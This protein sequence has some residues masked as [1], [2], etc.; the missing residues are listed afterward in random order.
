MNKTLFD[1]IGIESFD[2]IDENQGYQNIVFR[3]TKRDFVTVL[4]WHPF[5]LNDESFWAKHAEKIKTLLFNRIKFNDKYYNTEQEFLDFLNQNYPRYSPQEKMDNLLEYLHS[6][7]SF[8]GEIINYE[9]T[10][11]DDS[12]QIWRKLYF[13][14][15]A[16]LDFYMN[17]LNSQGL[18]SFEEYAGIGSY[19]NMVLTL[20]G[21][22][23]LVSIEERK[24]S[25]FCFVA[26]SFSKELEPIYD[27][28]ILP[29]LLETDF[30]PIIVSKETIDSDKTINDAIIAGI[31][32]S[33]F[34]IAEFTEHRAGVYFEAG[35]ALGRG[36]KV[37]YSCRKSDIDKAHFDTRN[38]QHIVWETYEELKEALIN[39]IRA[40]ILD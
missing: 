1:I 13:A 38:F 17:N 40:Y 34:T 31:K 26:M 7:T 28:A 18:I 30:K 3:S 8:D 14:N 23:K 12:L 21:L 22:T 10:F 27:A 37:I 39:K 20:E 5:D 9:S 35:Y 15:P 11:G 32:R 33:R 6:L 2:T 25:R 36:Q 4:K 19:Q 16:E 24:Y 29:S